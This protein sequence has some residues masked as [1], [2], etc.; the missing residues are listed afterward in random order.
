MPTPI[1]EQM[2][3]ALFAALQAGLAADGGPAVTVE[4]N[5][6]PPAQGDALPLVVQ[7]DAEGE[8]EVETEVGIDRITATLAFEGYVTA[9]DDAAMGPA[10]NGLEARVVKA[11]TAAEPGISLIQNI[12]RQG[13]ARSLDREGSP[14][15][16]AFSVTLAVE[17]WTVQGDPFTAAP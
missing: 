14:I 11:L 13:T 5:R 17:Y 8:E 16:A 4:R 3:S 9:T 6:R 7:L 15:T 10:Q 12:R 1:R 2:L